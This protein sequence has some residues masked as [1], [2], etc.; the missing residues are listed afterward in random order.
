MPTVST[1][2][3]TTFNPITPSHP[4]KNWPPGIVYLTSPIYSPNLPLTTL[5]LLRTITPTSN[6]SST[7]T[8]TVPRPANTRTVILPITNPSHP[9]HGQFGLFAA[10]DLRPNTFILCYL[11]RV[12]SNSGEDTDPESDYDLSLDRDLGVGV[13]AR[14]AG[15]EGRFINDYRGVPCSTSTSLSRHP[16]LP[17]YPRSTTGTNTSTG[18]KRDTA[19][20]M[21]GPN[22]EFRDVWTEVEDGMVEKR[23]GVFVLT[24]G[25]SG[26]RAAGIRA[27]EEVLVSY[28]KGF[29]S[30]RSGRGE[31]GG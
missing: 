27:G 1:V 12:H 26:K 21:K 16:E 30:E 13:D 5:D 24:A 18:K 2:Q 10:Q 6:T 14:Y 19:T 28:G 31:V 23:I 7:L 29:W 3:K 25:K 20:T 11:G 15:N 17:H 4:P 8:L 9:A 22:A